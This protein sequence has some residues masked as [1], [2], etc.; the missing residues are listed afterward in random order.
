MNPDDFHIV[1]PSTASV[2]EFPS[3][4]SNQYKVRLPQP[5]TLSGPQW[6][7][8]LASISLP[9]SQVNLRKLIP[10]MNYVMAMKWAKVKQGRRTVYTSNVTLDDLEVMT[11]VIDGEHLMRAIVEAVQKERVEKTQ[12]GELLTTPDGKQNLYAT[13]QWIPYGQE[14]DL[15]IDN[16]KSFLHTLFSPWVQIDLE[17]ALKMGWIKKKEQGDT[18]VLGP[19][20]LRE[21]HARTLST[22][23]QVLGVM[24]N[25]QRQPALWI[26]VNDQYV[27]LSGRCNW[28]FIN[29]NT[30]FRNIGG[31]PRRPLY[32]YSN[33][34]SSTMVGGQIVDLLREVQ[35][36]RE[37]KGSLYFEP[38]RILYHPV[39]NPVL[40][41]IDI[42]IAETDGTL[43][44]LVPTQ[45]TSLTLTFKKEGR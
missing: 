29:L 13:F 3:N 24:S 43:A 33:V 11:S 8:G 12:P 35:Y 16:S 39:R 40:D 27:V 2:D 9:D 42:A 41:V 22:D 31:D 44:S 20:L 26:V 15:L 10:K 25:A 32:I 23:P 38:R 34:G 17:F 6:Y 14:V 19:N 36:K 18:Y 30:A 28:R 37:G 1:L 4:T 5:L 45:P 7:V 21:T